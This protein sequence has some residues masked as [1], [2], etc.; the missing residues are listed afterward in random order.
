MKHDEEAQP[1]DK[2]TREREHFET[3][4]KLAINGLPAPVG[5]N[6]SED[7][8]RYRKRRD[9]TLSYV[10]ALQQIIE[11]LCKGRG[12]RPQPLAPYHYEMALEYRHRALAANA[13]GP[14]S[15]SEQEP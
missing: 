9:A 6:L 5:A 4:G 3:Q 2:R 15:T 1:D 14:D 11:D 12:L 7:V 8:D 13:R 10:V